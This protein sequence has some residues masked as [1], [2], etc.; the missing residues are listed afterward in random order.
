ML[1]IKI[2]RDS[3]CKRSSWNTEILKSR[4]QEVIHHLIFT[5]HRLNKFRMCIDMFNQPVRIFT[6]LEEICLFLCWL[7]FTPTVRTFSINQLW[8]CK[9]CLTRCTVHSFIISFVNISLLIQLFKDFLNLFLMI[10]ICRTNKFIIRCIHQICNLFYLCSH[11]VYKFFRCH[12]SFLSL[13]FNLLSMFVSSCLEKYIIPLTSFVSCDCISKYKLISISNVW[14]A[15]CISNRCC[16]IKFF[17]IHFVSSSFF[18]YTHL[19]FP[20]K[21][22]IFKKDLT[23]RVFYFIIFL[24]TKNSPPQKRRREIPVVPLLFIRSSQREPYRVPCT[25]RC[26]GRIPLYHTFL[27]YSLLD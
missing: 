27:S 16:H 1:W 22:S 24:E 5:G 9:E 18:E 7:Y 11:T 23:R 25:P 15:W 2:Y 6:H 17:L 12:S 20:L 8:F 26:K 3:P 4:E 14:F 10:F 19:D 21:S 13:Q